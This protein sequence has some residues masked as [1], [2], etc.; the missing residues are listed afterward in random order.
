MIKALVYK[1]KKAKADTWLPCLMPWV[2]KWLIGAGFL[3]GLI[4]GIGL[5]VWMLYIRGIA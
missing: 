2:W 1:I 4:I 3:V 5:A